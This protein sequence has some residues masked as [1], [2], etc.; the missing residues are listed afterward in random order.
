VCVGVCVVCA[1]SKLSIWLVDNNWRGGRMA[2]SLRLPHVAVLIV[3]NRK[4]WGFG[5]KSSYHFG[6]EEC[7][8]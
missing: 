1:G 5:I 4:G 2:G 7:Y 6:N 8:H 3:L